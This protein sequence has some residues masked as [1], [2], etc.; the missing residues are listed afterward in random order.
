MVVPFRSQASAIRTLLRGDRFAHHP[1]ALQTTIDTVDRFQGQEREVIL[2]SFATSCPDF[3]NLLGEF[4]LLPPRLN[5]AVTRAK[6]K[7]ILLH[8]TALREFAEAQAPYSESAALFL[9]LLAAATRL[10][11]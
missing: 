8:S 7:V 10:D 1:D 9:S 3:L 11:P 6:T 2:Y 4:L 5:V